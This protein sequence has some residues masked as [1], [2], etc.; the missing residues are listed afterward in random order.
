MASL[1]D[2]VL[3]HIM[4]QWPV[5]VKLR[6]VL[7]PWPTE[8]RIENRTKYGVIQGVPKVCFQFVFEN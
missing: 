5:G 3:F 2:I 1:P 8:T 4:Q 7:A 6:R